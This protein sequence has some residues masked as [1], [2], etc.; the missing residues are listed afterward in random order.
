MKKPHDHAA[1]PDPPSR[2]PFPDLNAPPAVGS[3]DIGSG[4]ARAGVGVAPGTEHPADATGSRSAGVNAGAN[5]D[6]NV[7]A[8]AP[9]GDAGFASELAAHKDR[10]VRLYA[11]YD[12]FRKRTARERLEAEQRGMGLLIRGILESLDDLARFAHLDPATTDA[13][14]VI[15]GAD[16]VERKLMK[17]LSGHGL[18]VVNP[19]GLPFDPTFQEALTTVPAESA[20]EDHIVAQVY[21]VGYVFNGLLLRPARVVVKQW[22]GG[23]GGGAS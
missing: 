18:E 13:K 11:E 2:D 15:E 8:A 10:Y 16:L 20:A 1:S 4:A 6:V 3:S 21:Q 19:V 7:D 22:H 5:A 23:S 9:G 14:T 17:S 12:N